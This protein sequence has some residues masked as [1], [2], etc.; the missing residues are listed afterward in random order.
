MNRNAQYVLR[1]IYRWALMTIAFSLLLFSAAGS[2]KIVSLRAY[3]ITYSFALL[4]TT[5]AVD[6]AL[7]HER[8]HPGPDAGPF[9]LQFGPRFLFLLTLATAAFCVGRVPT[10][11]VASRIRWFA[12]AIF[13][14]ASFVQI[15][16]MIANP[17]FSPAIRTQRE[18]HRLIDSGP[19]KFMR[20]PGYFA[21]CVSAPASPIAIGSWLALVPA[22][23]FIC[24]IY[25]RSK[26]EDQFLK[27]NLPSYTQYAAKVPSGMFL[28]RGRE[29]QNMRRS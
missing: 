13:A 20:H 7:A 10:L 6:P 4:V 8:S 11:T 25:C 28:F 14:L 5:L 15:W 24:L 2:T 22:A 29:C 3:L 18:R 23:A 19:Y 1:T 26:F 16:A 9:H 12:L 17:F 21:M 27:D